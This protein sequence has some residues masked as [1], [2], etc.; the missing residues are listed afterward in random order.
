MLENALVIIEIDPIMY[1]RE[2]HLLIDKGN[3]CWNNT[4]HTAPIQLSIEV[5][6][7]LNQP[8]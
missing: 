2:L 3:Y 6:Q 7:M 5:A 4:L 8:R 1:V